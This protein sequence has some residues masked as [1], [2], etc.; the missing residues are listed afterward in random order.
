MLRL[1][2]VQ[3]RSYQVKFGSGQATTDIL[4][5]GICPVMSGHVM[6]W[7]GEVRS[8]QVRSGECQI[9]PG[10]VRSVQGLVM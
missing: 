7:A 5:S 8:G 3:V 9:W 6:S 1:I 10:Q 4:R 2:K